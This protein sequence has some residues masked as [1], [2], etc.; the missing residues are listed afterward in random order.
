MAEITNK[1][2]LAYNSGT[3]THSIE[4]NTAKVVLQ[5][6]MVI[7]KHSLESAYRIGDTLTYNILVSN[8]SDTA[9]SGLT[10]KDDLGTYTYKEGVVVTPLTYLDIAQKYENEVNEGSITGTIAA[11]KHSVTFSVGALAAK[12]TV[13]IQYK[14]KTNEFAGATVGTSTIK[15][16]ATATATSI[17]TPVTAEHTLSVDSYAEMTIDK[18]MSPNPVVDGGIL[19]YLFELRNYGTID[20]T[21]VVLSDTFAPAPTISTG[22]VL[23]NNTTTDNYD[24]TGSVF[25]LPDPTAEPVVP[26]TVPKA[27]FEVNTTTGEIVRIPG[28]TTV[29]VMGEI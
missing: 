8:T 29:K 19:S 12:T 26:I 10:I 4:S 18:T 25:T 3:V 28:I 7:T 13:L 14:V 2:S 23:L 11:D 15:N 20:A 21:S 6:P 9:L 27:T 16:T 22:G 17:A 24:Y 5:G 1:A